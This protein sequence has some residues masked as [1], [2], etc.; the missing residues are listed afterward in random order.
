[1]LTGSKDRST[2]DSLMKVIQMIEM[3]QAIDPDINIEF[4]VPRHST[5]GDRYP[6]EL[7]QVVRYSDSGKWCVIKFEEFPTQHKSK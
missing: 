3:L 2:K 1:M 6:A 4:E 7:V 5:A